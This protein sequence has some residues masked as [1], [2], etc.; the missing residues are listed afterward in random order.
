MRVVL[1]AFW[2]AGGPPSG[3]RVL[4]SMISTWAA[5]YP[6]D[7]LHLVAPARVHKEL[8]EIAPG[9]ILHNTKVPRHALSNAYRLGQVSNYVNA[10][11]TVSQNFGSLT[12]PTVTFI[13]DAIYERHP[14]WFTGQ[15]RAYLGLISAL[16]L[17]TKRFV[18]SSS[19]EADQ[20]RRLKWVRGK[21]VLVNSLAV[22]IDIAGS[23][24]S[25]PEHVPHDAFYFLAVGRLN[26]RKNLGR[27][28]EAYGNFRRLVGSRNTC[29]EL[30]IV[31]VPDGKREAERHR[32]GV[33]YLGATT[34]GELA[35]LYRHCR[36]FFFPSLDEGFGIP[37]I[38]ARHFGATVCASNIPPVRESLGDAALYFDPTSVSSILEVMLKVYEHSTPQPSQ[39]RTAPADSYSWPSFVAT[40]RSLAEVSE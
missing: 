22:P 36:A 20:I 3:Y 25:R 11:L 24:R 1:D 29:P 32:D 7:E 18:T 27:L 40:L 19:Y 15:E 30:L 8:A 14:E 38:E 37:P 17:R 12:A 9:A 10:A 39:T 5:Q 26:V 35:W 34:D 33:D 21:P 13:H 2:F 16:S 31:G 6:G 28:T 4:R 23:V